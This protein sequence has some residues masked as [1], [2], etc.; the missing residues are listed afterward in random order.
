[1][2]IKNKIDLICKYTNLT[3]PKALE[4]LIQIE[5]TIRMIEVYKKSINFNKNYFLLATGYI[6]RDYT[7]KRD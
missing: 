7:L 5:D 3:Q 4:N 2:Q 6:L 1:M